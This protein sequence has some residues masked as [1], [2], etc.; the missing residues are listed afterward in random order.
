MTVE[1]FGEFEPGRLEKCKA[2]Q[3]FRCECLVGNLGARAACGGSS[4]QPKRPFAP[5]LGVVGS[6]LEATA[7]HTMRTLTDS[8]LTVATTVGGGSA[9]TGESIQFLRRYWPNTQIV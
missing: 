3:E 9:A 2:I 4:K 1:G 7:R 5:W 6:L 8:C